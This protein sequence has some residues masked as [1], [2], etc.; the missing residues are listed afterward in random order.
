MAVPSRMGIPVRLTNAASRGSMALAMFDSTATGFSVL[1]KTWFATWVYPVSGTSSVVR[2]TQNASAA[3][4]GSSSN[5]CMHSMKMASASFPVPHASR[6]LTGGSPSSRTAASRCVVA[7]PILAK[8]TPASPA[9]SMRWARS[10]PESWMAARP[11]GPARRPATM[12]SSVSAISSSVFTRRTPY[13][14][15]SAS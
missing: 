12:S 7:S 2:S 4:S 13:A 8:A 3:V 1:A 5:A 11:P 9:A 14:S 10:P 15:N 6:G